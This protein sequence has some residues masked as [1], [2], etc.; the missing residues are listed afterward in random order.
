MKSLVVYESMFGNTHTVA[1]RIATGLAAGGEASAVSV[2]EA[3]A[4]RVAGADLIVVGAPTHVHGL[5]RAAS[6]KSAPDEARKH[7]DLELDPHAEGDGVRDWLRTLDD[8]DHRAAAAFDTRFDAAPALTG[9][10]SKGIDRRLRKHHFHTIAPPE[11]FL[12]DRQNHLVERE[13]DR[14]REWGEALLALIEHEQP[15]S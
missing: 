9:R 10:A 5:S 11:S 8:G 2:E 1:D 7:D 12:V 15:L 13:A 14:A 3:T 6:R 4:E